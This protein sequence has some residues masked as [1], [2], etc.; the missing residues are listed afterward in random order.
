MR[1]FLIFF[2]FLFSS[3]G[4]PAQDFFTL[5][6][7]KAVTEY[8]EYGTW[9]KE[10]EGVIDE[11]MKKVR[12]LRKGG[13]STA[14]F[15][16]DETCMSN[17]VLFKELGFVLTDSGWNAWTS[18][19]MSTA[20]PP[21]KKLYDYLIA[22]NYRIIFLTGRDESIYRATYNNLIK[23]GYTKFDTLI[24]KGSDISQL[25]AAEYKS[26][27]RKQ[28]TEAGYNIVVNTGDQWSDLE[29]GNSGLMI[30]IPNYLYLI[31]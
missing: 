9:E 10:I 17:F 15:D 31:R 14:V 13:M 25:T 18:A 19:K 4:L 1:R 3:A 6:Q 11:A 27:V 2:V 7:T 20:I 26:T 8:Y 22:E 30:R 16:I 21:V 24:C 28:L 12:E 23:E 5:I 29:G